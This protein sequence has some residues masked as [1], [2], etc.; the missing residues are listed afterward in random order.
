MDSAKPTKNQLN[1]L[2]I[3]DIVQ[4]VSQR[5]GVTDTVGNIS[6]FFLI[7]NNAPNIYF[8]FVVRSAITTKCADENKMFRQR[9]EKKRKVLHS[10]E[11]ANKEN[12]LDVKLTPQNVT[13]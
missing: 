2:I 13:L 10:M 9:M 12:D 3:A 6:D 5:C 11:N 4:F 8:K 1:P 7:Q